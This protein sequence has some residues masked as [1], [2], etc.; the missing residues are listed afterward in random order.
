MTG[1][2]AKGGKKN[3]KYGRN[4]PDAIRY[5]AE[6]RYVRNKKRKLDRHLNRHPKDEQALT[7]RHPPLLNITT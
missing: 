6:N 7:A 4:K 5:K 1:V 2:V 3:R